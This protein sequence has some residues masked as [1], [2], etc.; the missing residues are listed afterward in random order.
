MA[1]PLSCSFPACSTLRFQRLPSL[2]F[3]SPA[4][5]EANAPAAAH[6]HSS[7]FNPCCARCLRFACIQM[8][9]GLP[10]LLACTG[11]DATARPVFFHSWHQAGWNPEGVLGLGPNFLHSSLTFP[12]HVQPTKHAVSAGWQEPVA[13][14]SASLH[15]NWE[16]NLWLGLGWQHDGVMYRWVWLLGCVCVCVGGGAVP[17]C[18]RHTSRAQFRR[19]PGDA[20]CL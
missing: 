14:R 19:K 15:S 20:A 16:G 13:T 17:A 18:I 2:S 8:S 1:V 4:N 9:G 6:L 10:T 7:F 11:Q 5:K 12:P 3:L